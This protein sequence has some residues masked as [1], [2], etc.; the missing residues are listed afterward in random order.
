M[1]VL[2]VAGLWLRAA[3]K[4][5]VCG[6]IYGGYGEV[7][8]E[9]GCGA[10]RKG[11]KKQRSG[12]ICL[13]C[14]SS[15]LCDAVHQRSSVLGRRQGENGKWR[16]RSKEAKGAVQS[17]GTEPEEVFKKHPLLQLAALKNIEDRKELLVDYGETSMFWKVHNTHFLKVE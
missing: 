6:E 1:V 10:G 3:A 12:V 16:N 7:V 14:F 8:L 2:R 13:S 17:S 15:I 11:F 4:Q 5:A 9:V